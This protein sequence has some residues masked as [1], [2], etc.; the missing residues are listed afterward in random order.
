MK[1]AHRCSK[2]RQVSDIDIIYK[3]IYFNILLIF[4][5]KYALKRIAGLIE[6]PTVIYK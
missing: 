5:C 1:L 6:Y 3:H 2:I 4:A